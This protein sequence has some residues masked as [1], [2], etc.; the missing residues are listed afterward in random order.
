[1]STSAQDQHKEAIYIAYDK[2]TGVI[3]H[4]H[5]GFHAETKKAMRCNL[6]E[7][8]ALAISDPRLVKRLSKQTAEDL[9]VLELL[10][11]PA[12]QLP[13]SRYFLVDPVSKSLKRKPRLRLIPEKTKLQGNGTDSLRIQINVIS[14]KDKPIKY[15]GKVKVKTNRGKLSHEAGIVEIV[16]GKGTISLTS[17]NET[18]A[19]VN[20][21]VAAL[22]GSCTTDAVDL[23][24]V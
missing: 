10:S 3:L 2:K 6:D 17:V 14:E 15:E 4:T 18:I 24:F 7:I 8:K 5:Q 20:V 23:E 19:Q 21:S 16:G 9:D 12:D 22:D 1:M 13:L 11:V